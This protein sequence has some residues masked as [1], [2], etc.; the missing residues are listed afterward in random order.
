M[1]EKETATNVR[2]G[3]SV[4]TEVPSADEAHV[5]ALLRE[6]AGYARYERTDRVTAVDDE[7]KK[8]GV[9][10][11]GPQETAVESKPRRTATRSK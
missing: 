4:A 3:E 7:L 10:V 6:R 2:T 8:L 11:P 9:A 5:A 1:P